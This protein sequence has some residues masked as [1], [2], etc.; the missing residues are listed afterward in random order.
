M[1][2]TP[3]SPHPLFVHL[4]QGTVDIEHLRRKISTALE[5]TNEVFFVSHFCYHW[6]T[7][8][9]FTR[10]SVD[11]TNQTIGDR[12]FNSSYVRGIEVFDRP[13]SPATS[14]ACALPSTG[15]SR[16]SCHPRD[17]RGALTNAACSLSPRLFCFAAARHLR[18][19]PVAL[20]PAQLCQPR[21]FSPYPS[22]SSVHFNSQGHRRHRSRRPSL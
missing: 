7:M 15:R 8:R 19:S 10:P 21:V 1:P 9:F 13:W 2:S 17:K 3:C 18:S 12:K 11:E 6:V 20:A 16:S 5:H 14:A 22:D 4:R